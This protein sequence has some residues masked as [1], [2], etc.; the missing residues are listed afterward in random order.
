MMYECSTGDDLGD[1]WHDRG[2]LSSVERSKRLD[3][4]RS[5]ENERYQVK[6]K[7]LQFVEP[8]GEFEIPLQDGL[9]IRLTDQASFGDKTFKLVRIR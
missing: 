1:V 6:V 8:R 7:E 2:R 5:V 9:E 3:A 4:K